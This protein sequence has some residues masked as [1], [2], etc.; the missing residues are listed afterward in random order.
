MVSDW[1]RLNVCGSMV[2]TWPWRGCW[3]K[4]FKLRCLGQSTAARFCSATSWPC[5]GWRI[6]SHHAWWCRNFMESLGA[7]CKNPI[8]QCPSFPFCTYRPYLSLS[9]SVSL[10][11]LLLYNL[12]TLHLPLYIRGQ[13]NLRMVAIVRQI[14]STSR[15]A[16][17][18]NDKSRGKTP[19]PVL[20]HNYFPFFRPT[21]A[22]N[23]GTFNCPTHP[24]FVFHKSSISR[25]CPLTTCLVVHPAML[26]NVRGC[27]DRW[28]AWCLPPYGCPATGF[29][30][31]DRLPRKKS[32]PKPPFSYVFTRK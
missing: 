5:P 17:G 26:L 32:S 7:F 30:S 4:N 10:P 12:Y 18:V 15:Y 13:N 27:H 16:G 25:I 28:S 14:V 9:L 11:P 1:N 8:I 22:M 6:R 20:D 2:A 21:N 23:W 24:H 3:V 29:P 19:K 31:M